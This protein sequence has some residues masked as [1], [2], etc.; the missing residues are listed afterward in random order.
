MKLEFEA[1]ADYYRPVHIKQF[2]MVSVPE[3]ATRVA[4]LERGEADIVYFM[5]GRTDRPREEQSEAAPGA[6]GLRQLVARV[7]RLPEPVEPVPRQAR[8]AG[9]QPGGRSRRDQRRRVRRHGRGRRQLDQRR[10]RIRAGMAEMGARHRQ[11]EA[12]DGRGRLSQRL[13][14]RLGDADAELLLA[15]RAHRVAA[16]GDRH[17]LAAAGDGARRVSE[18]DAGRPAGMAGRADHLQRHAH[19]RHLVELVRLDVQVRRLQFARTSSASR[20]ST[21]SSAST[22]PRSTA[23]SASSSPS[24][25]RRRSSRNITSCRCSAMPS[26]MR[27]DRASPCRNGRT[28]SRRS[29]PATPIRGRTSADELRDQSG[30]RRWASSSSGGRSTPWSRCS[31]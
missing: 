15:R 16:S 21:T 23:T 7:P 2:T 19:R 6:G 8:A 18:E 3:A 10:R 22:W 29:P 30:G 25:S 28:C 13:Q 9:D 4:M 1:F 14:R 24:R 17:P 26:S 12:A 20:S 31:S 5:P 11:G 27:S